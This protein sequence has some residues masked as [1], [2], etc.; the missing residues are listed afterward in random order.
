MVVSASCGSTSA[1]TP[2][3]PTVSGSSQGVDPPDP[4]QAAE[5][6][7][8][9]KT[10][11][12]TGRVLDDW[13]GE[14]IRGATVCLQQGTIDHSLCQVRP[15]EPKPVTTTDADGRF[16]FDDVPS[17]KIFVSAARDG[18]VLAL[19]HR[20]GVETWSETRLTSNWNVVL[21]L[22]PPASISGIARDHTGAVIGKDAANGKIELFAINYWGGLPA[23]PNTAAEPTFK[24]DGTYHFDNLEPGRYFLA[25]NPGWS[26]EEPEGTRHNRPIG[27]VS[28]R[29]PGPTSRN[30]APFFT[31]SEGEQKKLDL[32][33]PEKTLHHVSL[34][35]GS[36]AG[37]ELRS[38][39][40]FRFG[41]QQQPRDKDA[42]YAWLPDGR[43]WLMSQSP[44]D[45]D[46]AVFFKVAGADVSG[47]H[48]ENSAWDA[49]RLPVTVQVSIAGSS[50]LQCGPIDASQCDVAYLELL[51]P[52]PAGTVGG[53]VDLE[54]TASPK[55]VATTLLPG[56]YGAV[57]MARKNLYV[58][59]IRS[60]AFDFAQGPL[61]V[62]KGQAPAPIQIELAP[63]AKIQ[64]VVE[65]DRKPVA[66]YVYALASGKTARANYR[67]FVPVE[68]KDDGTFEMEGLAPGSWIVFASDTGNL[69]LD[70]RNPA[71][72]AYWGRHGTHLHARTGHTAHVVV[73]EMLKPRR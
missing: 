30:H 37:F 46:R 69:Q 73:K 62:H 32:Q 63:A 49:T 47:L 70:V 36:A 21:Y 9:D 11:R 40:G 50:V 22:V 10:Y 4:S 18:Y 54:L 33:I 16:A 44:G 31:L 53:G 1:Q 8:A 51:A 68:S 66:A 35:G 23:T 60:G 71:D 24:P 7:F 12:V 13:T 52:D 41:V 67:L 15:P 45:G 55:P 65:R 3:Q 59:S 39:N 72:T 34:T 17:G 38:L 28:L 29:Y 27:E 20:V 58:R 43:Y 26:K 5:L 2:V 61:P 6:Q 64:G 42:Y 14:P 48:L 25:V 56:H 19:H 57:V